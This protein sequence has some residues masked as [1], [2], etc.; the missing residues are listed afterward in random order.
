M[1][2][3]NGAE[4]AYPNQPTNDSLFEPSFGLTKR[5]YMA[6]L[7]LQGI[8]ANANASGFRSAVATFA[9]EMADQLLAAL[10]ESAK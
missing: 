1:Q 5:E 4:S 10:E 8:L 6:T 3:L 2:L 7:C 9:V